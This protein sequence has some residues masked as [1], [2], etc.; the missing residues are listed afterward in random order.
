MSAARRPVTRSL[1]KPHLE[2]VDFVVEVSG[3]TG[4][5]RKKAEQTMKQFIMGLEA[6]TLS[7][8]ENLFICE[9]QGGGW[10]DKIKAGAKVGAKVGTGI[11][12]VG[13]TAIG[14]AKLFL[15]AADWRPYIDNLRLASQKFLKNASPEV[16]ANINSF[17]E[18]K[19]DLDSINDYCTKR[20]SLLIKETCEILDPYTDLADNNDYTMAQFKEALVASMS[21]WNNPYV[22]TGLGAIVI[23]M[24]LFGLYKY[25]ERSLMTCA[26]VTGKAAQLLENDLTQM[27][28]EQLIEYCQQYPQR[29]Q[30]CK[31]EKQKR[32]AAQ[33]QVTASTK[34]ASQKAKGISTA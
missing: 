12:A 28:L 9:Q 34:N 23:F 7:K 18:N 14:A 11:A 13:A 8:I 17:L 10:K 4:E 29:Q 2:Y 24:A 19:I 15:A 1:T 21:I 30:Q 22:Q 16:M 25:I 27:N 32:K 3:L 26:D 6:D 20:T 31:T 5:D 33:G